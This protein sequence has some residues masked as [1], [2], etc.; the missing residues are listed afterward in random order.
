MEGRALYPLG[1]PP[2]RHETP[3]RAPGRCLKRRR[4]REEAPRPRRGSAG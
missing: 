2:H 4:G 3:R 1:T